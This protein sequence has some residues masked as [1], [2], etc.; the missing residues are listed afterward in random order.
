MSGKYLSS[1]H[2]ALYRLVISR[3]LLR[4]TYDIIQGLH[5]TM[6]KN[7]FICGYPGFEPGRERFPSPAERFRLIPY[8]LF[9]ESNDLYAAKAASIS[10]LE[11]IMGEFLPVPFLSPFTLCSL[12]NSWSSEGLC[13]RDFSHLQTSRWLILSEAGARLFS[14]ASAPSVA[15]SMSRF[16][17]SK[18]SILIFMAI[19]F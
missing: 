12:F 17:S 15:A 19:S 16:F 9:T 8:R 3:Y 13:P 10:S 14:A 2:F 18:S 4:V 1:F 11:Y 7:A 5:V 6:S